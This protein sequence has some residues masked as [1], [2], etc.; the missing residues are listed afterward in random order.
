[1]EPSIDSLLL[2]DFAEVVNGKLYVMG[3][4]FTA[5]QIA[6]FEQSH[7]FF[8]AA[9]LRIPWTYTNQEIP[10]GGRLETLDAVPLECWS[11]EGQLEAGRAPGQRSGDTV[12]MFAAPVEVV[13]PEPMDVVLRF[14]FGSDER[15][16]RFSLVAAA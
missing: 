15:T 1:M 10:L 5:V 8:V 12:T 13:V 11:L 6:D 7:R 4:G 2:A 3:A 16:A 14:T 9:A